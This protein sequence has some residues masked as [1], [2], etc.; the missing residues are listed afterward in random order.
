[1]PTA[2][3]T[4]TITV[5]GNQTV[6]NITFDG[7]GYTLSGGTLTLGNPGTGVGTIT[8]NQ[9]AAI[10]SVIAGTAELDKEGPGT[11]TL[12]ANNTY[13]GGT[14]VNGGTLALAGGG[15]QIVG[16]VTINSGATVNVLGNWAL[17]SNAPSCVTGIAINGGVLAFNA[18]AQNG[19]TSASNITMTG[20]TISGTGFDWYNGIT[21]TPTLTTNA[22]NTTAVVSSAVNL[23][24]D[25]NYAIFNVAQGT[26]PSGID[27]LISGPITSGLY[28]G[29]GGNPYNG[30]GVVKTGAGVM[31]LAG[32][33][34]YYGGTTVAAGVLQVANAGALP[35]Y[36]DPAT[37]RS[38]RAPPC[39]SAPAAPAGPARTSA[40]STPAASRPARLS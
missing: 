32:A 11:L 24:L 38:T 31:C 39:S 4:S 3:R 8:T 37:S 35:G 30:D 23:R 7:A 10:N 29:N 9:D 15:D 5:N 13:T 34:A 22:S 26:T 20:G 12:N 33:N 25:N 14:T 21:S 1:M 19:G 28:W 6:G 18:G 40:A 2:A 16:N 27:L 17:G 36:N